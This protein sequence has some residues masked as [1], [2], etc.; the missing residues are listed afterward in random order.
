MRTSSKKS[1]TAA[2]SAKTSAKK[3][4]KR[5]APAKA[6]VTGLPG[7]AKRFVRNNPLRVLAGAAAIAVGVAKLKQHFA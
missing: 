7:R 2:K 1:R 3:I 6:A 4:S 5:A